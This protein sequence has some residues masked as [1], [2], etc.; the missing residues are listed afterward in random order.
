MDVSSGQGSP[1]QETHSSLIAN[2]ESNNLKTKQVI[3]KQRCGDCSGCRATECGVCKFCLNMRKFGGPGTLKQ[4]CV[5]RKCSGEVSSVTDS[6]S[7]DQD[8][9]S[10]HS[11]LPNQYT[12][13][14]NHSNSL[15]MNNSTNETQQQS[16]SG[17]TVI[18]SIKPITVRNNPSAT[19]AD[20]VPVTGATKPV[21]VELFEPYD[22]T[23]GGE[24]LDRV[25]LGFDSKAAA[26]F[27]AL[28]SGSAMSRC[29][30]MVVSNVSQ[31]T[32]TVDEKIPNKSQKKDIRAAV[33]D[34]VIMEKGVRAMDMSPLPTYI[35]GEGILGNPLPVS[36]HAAV[37]NAPEPV[38]S[39]KAY[40]NHFKAPK[41]F[42][43]DQGQLIV[44]L[45]QSRMGGNVVFT[46]KKNNSMN[47]QKESSSSPSNLSVPIEDDNELEHKSHQIPSDVRLLSDNISNQIIDDNLNNSPEINQI[48]KQEQAQESLISVPQEEVQ[49][50]A[51]VSI[52]GHEESMIEEQEQESA[53][54][55]L[56]NRGRKRKPPPVTDEP[57]PSETETIP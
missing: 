23:V 8:M 18:T 28:E 21:E 52:K 10:P 56:K 51:A 9:S 4:P 38:V 7:T 54:D 45:H 55:R 2:N 27:S 40:G 25:K 24:I 26:F 16:D 37:D 13:S 6:N 57:T 3:R 46:T 1:I 53:L 32:S 33:I 14:K 48:S 29:E 49:Q 42:R 43:N 15:H 39:K 50:A 41:P 22:P 19:T 17:F 47:T 35:Q 31:P 30:C 44:T 36:A 5:Q 34:A 11:S 20:V 12:S